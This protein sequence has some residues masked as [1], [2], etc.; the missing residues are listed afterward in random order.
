MSISLDATQKAVEELY[1]HTL[2]RDGLDEDEDDCC[3]NCRGCLCTCKFLRDRIKKNLRAV[4][5]DVILLRGYRGDTV[6]DDG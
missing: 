5:C 4:L 1:H 6:L 3:L 2:L